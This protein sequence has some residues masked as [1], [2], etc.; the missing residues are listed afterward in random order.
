MRQLQEEEQGRPVA[1][2]FFASPSLAM[3]ASLTAALTQVSVSSKETRVQHLFWEIQTGVKRRRGE[4]RFHGFKLFLSRC[5][6][7]PFQQLISP[8][9]GLRPS[10]ASSPRFPVAWQGLSH[11]GKSFTEGHGGEVTS[12]FLF[13]TE[14]A[15]PQI[16]PH[17][18][19]SFQVVVPHCGFL[20]LFKVP[21]TQMRPSCTS[22]LA[23]LSH[24]GCNTSGISHSP[25]LTS[26]FLQS[27]R[28]F[29]APLFPSLSATER[30]PQQP[31]LF[32]D[33][34]PSV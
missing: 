23:A 26:L 5:C 22:A 34:G 8:V 24:G 3:T 33:S 27:R 18:L 12:R 9:S 14:Q 32:K 19:L 4:T 17:L 20:F 2:R 13:M 16:A 7:P 15:L 30:M 11:L 1:S 25:H 6:F 29:T 21:L 10:P 31:C 28:L